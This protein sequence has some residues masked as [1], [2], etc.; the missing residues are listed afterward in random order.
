[1]AEDRRHDS[2][3]L[4][5]LA[6][7]LRESEERLRLIV[8]NARDY[9]IF[10]IDPEARVIDWREGAEAVFGFS[11]EEMAG[12]DA[13]IL[14]TP[15]D[16][17]KGVPE[18]ER[19]IARAQGKAPNVRWHVCKDGRRVFIDGIATALRDPEGKL[20]GYLKIGQDVTERHSAEERRKTLL[21]ELQ[22][23]VRNTLAVV[24]SIVRRTAQNSDSLED[25]VDH[26]QGRIDAFARVQAVVTRDL[27][28]GV[29]LTAL[30]EDELL[31]H[32]TR[33][34]PKLT[35][36]GPDLVLLA[37]PAEAMS[38]AIHE[39]ATNSVKYGALG[40]SEGAVR[41]SWTRSGSNGGETLD[42]IWA[43]QGRDRPL[44][45]ADRAGF[46][47]E[48]LQRRPGSSSSA[49]ASASPCECRSKGRPRPSIADQVRNKDWPL[50][51]QGPP[52]RVRQ[53][54]KLQIGGIEAGGED[55]PFPVEDD[56]LA[57]R[58]ADQF[59]LP[60]RPQRP[61]DVDGSEAERVGHLFLGDREE[62]GAVGEAVELV[63]ADGHL[64]QQVSEAAPRVPSPD[65][66]QPL[67]DDVAV[68]DAFP[69]ESGGDG[70]I[71]DGQVAKRR[72]R[73]VE[74]GGRSERHQ[75]GGSRREDERVEIGHVARQV[76]RDE[77]A[78]A[79]LH[80][81]E[82][83]DEAV[84][85]EA[86]LLDRL[87]RPHDVAMRLDPAGSGRQGEHGLLLFG[88]KLGAGA[89]FAEEKP[90]AVRGGGK[91]HSLLL[92][93]NA[94]Y[95][96][97][98]RAKQLLVPFPATPNGFD[99]SR[100]ED[101]AADDDRELRPEDDQP[102]GPEPIY[103]LEE[104]VRGRA[105]RLDVRPLST[106]ERSMTRPT[107]PPQG[108]RASLSS[109]ASFCS[110]LLSSQPARGSTPMKERMTVVPVRMLNATATRSSASGPGRSRATGSITSSRKAV[111]TSS[112]A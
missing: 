111:L 22:H 30:I 59:L 64:A 48:L 56:D 93:V 76:E 33:E 49:R 80:L 65:A 106:A 99:E 46:G 94:L 39:L 91:T 40:T 36:E 92:S 105:S 41:V 5:R 21:A 37:K 89:D 61:V 29:D 100:K 57:P 23:R 71:A 73:D 45:A 27:V 35:I 16:R 24:R 28:G 97:L 11:R 112:E 102:V 63:R 62:K 19:A 18:E 53:R 60:Q 15:E 84:G 20:T 108:E 38:L 96:H 82:S 1:M 25:M 109:W 87:A 13:D 74:E 44:V 110:S 12:Q 69:P 42:F 58:R 67:G 88:R 8:E 101:D 32:G 98:K 75:R 4:E 78:L 3:S 55:E 79:V 7:A 81:R 14:Y 10:M 103:L 83:R 43:E 107:G 9:A 26:L 51:G 86:G 95:R 66:D 31:A 50:A 70:R 17:S 34:G 85:D 54:R 68:D 72:M 47:F 2:E 77:L 52:P 6:E 90:Q 104:P